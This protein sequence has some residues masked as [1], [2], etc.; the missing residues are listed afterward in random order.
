[1]KS[2]NVS[3]F[4]QSSADRKVDSYIPFPVSTLKKSNRTLSNVQP[5]IWMNHGSHPPC[6]RRSSA[7][8]V[9]AHLQSLGGKVAMK[10]PRFD[11]PHGAVK[12]TCDLEDSIL[13]NN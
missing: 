1:M 6:G 13:T 8:P 7:E 3:W 9:P 2:S 11:A 4:Q 12:A 5:V 10:G